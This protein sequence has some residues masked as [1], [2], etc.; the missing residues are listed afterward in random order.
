MQLHEIATMPAVTCRP[1]RTITDVAREMHE[2]EVGCVI[3][4]DEADHIAGIVTDRDL[5]V[6]ALA[7]EQPGTTPV[8]QVMTHDVVHLHEDADL[9]AALNVMAAWGTRRV[10]IVRPDGVVVGL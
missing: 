6:R 3:V 9:D 4:T 7:K 2:N 10:P 8:A 5:V 1:T